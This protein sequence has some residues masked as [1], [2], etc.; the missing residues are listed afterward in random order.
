MRRFVAG[1]VAVIV[2]GAG[3]A[4]ASPPAAAGPVAA[5]PVAAALPFVRL[6][7]LGD[8]ISVGVGDPRRNGY[9][10]FLQNAL[11]RAGV[12]LDMVGSRVDGVPD[13]RVDRHNEG[14]SGWTSRDILDGRPGAGAQGS[15]DQW[16]RA[17]AP[18]VVLLQIG[19][20]D[21]GGGYS[22]GAYAAN[23]DRIIR[24]IHAGN[25]YAYVFVSNV[26]CTAQPA[27]NQLLE[28]YRRALPRVVEAAAA[29]SGGRV[30]LVE[31]SDIGCRAGQL[32]DTLH[33]N[34]AGY[35]VMSSRWYQSLHMNLPWIGLWGRS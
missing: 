17:A 25:R 32:A 20:N 10:A 4:I 7:V 13:R 29:R 35:Y 8:S 14:H 26:T 31:M 16:V 11:R 28:Q 23:V 19:T 18:N 24:T 1:L 2:V 9:R 21:A 15:L 27:R 30:H 3:L 5:G 12:R 34:P 6:M 33:P 22:A